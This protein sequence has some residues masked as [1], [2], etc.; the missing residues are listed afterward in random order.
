VGPRRV[1]AEALS[2]GRGEEL[3]FWCRSNRPR[4]EP[5]HDAGQAI[6]EP[7]GQKSGRIVPAL[8]CLAV[9]WILS[10]ATLEELAVTGAVA[11]IA[12]ILYVPRA[13]GRRDRG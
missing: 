5:A 4:L 12:T 11:A 13:A 8:A 10:N 9:G 7:V 2:R 6:A 3:A 1:A